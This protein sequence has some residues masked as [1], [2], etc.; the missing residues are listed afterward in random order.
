MSKRTCFGATLVSTTLV[1]TAFTAHAGNSTQQPILTRFAQTQSESSFELSATRFTDVE[2]DE[3]DHFDGW[4]AKAELTIPFED[5][6]QIRLSIPFY[7]DGD[8][9]LTKPG[10][11]FTGKIIDID[12]NGGVFDYATL[13]YE[14]QVRFADQ[15]NYNLAYTLGGGFRTKELDTTTGD[16]FNHTGRMLLLG[17]KADS[18]INGGD[19]QLLINAGIR[20][21]HDADDLNPENK[22][23]WTWADIKTAVI[24]S[25]WGERTQPV[26]EASY[27]G[28]FNDY[29]ELALVPELVFLLDKSVSLKLG[30][31]IGV[32]DDGN[33]A[34]AV[35]SLSINF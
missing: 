22:D 25:K 23:S 1:L 32:T 13:Q 6:K 9:R 35:G 14:H 28:D 24:F 17:A 11:S 19:S 4:T 15:S 26:I 16:K 21:Y 12:G 31:I 7:T 3:A 20:Y 34:G 27:L 29:N 2:L 18:Y 10:S 5:D 33:D 30:A 8:A